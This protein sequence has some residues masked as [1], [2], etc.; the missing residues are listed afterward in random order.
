MAYYKDVVKRIN[1][2]RKCLLPPEEYDVLTWN[3]QRPDFVRGSVRRVQCNRATSRIAVLGHFGLLEPV[4]ALIHARAG[5][6]PI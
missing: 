2:S 1:I 4:E 5:N 3:S 6:E